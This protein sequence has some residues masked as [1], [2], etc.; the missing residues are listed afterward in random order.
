MYIHRQ[1]EIQIQVTRDTSSDLLLN[2][3][4]R[5]VSNLK[6]FL[7]FLKIIYMLLIIC[8]DFFLSERKFL[9]AIRSSLFII[10]IH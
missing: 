10:Y 5:I 9:S 7:L 4:L 1:N 6:V 2:H 8:L 3:H